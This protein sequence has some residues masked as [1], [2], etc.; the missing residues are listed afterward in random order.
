MTL[1]K[2]VDFGPGRV[3]LATV[4]YTLTGGTR[5]TAGVAEIATGIYGAM[6]TFDDDFAGSIIWD[7][8]QDES[9]VYA[10]E[11]INTIDVNVKKVNDIAIDGS[12][13]TNDPWGPA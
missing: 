3:S 1:Y 12:G 8:G 6:I 13:T 11:D 2:T 9:T 4:G 10:V 7:T 5:I